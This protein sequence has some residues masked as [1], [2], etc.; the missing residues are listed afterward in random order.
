[1]SRTHRERSEIWLFETITLRHVAWV[2]W[3][4]SYGHC[5]RYLSMHRSMA[6]FWK[7]AISA[8]RL[9]LLVTPAMWSPDTHA[10]LPGLIEDHAARLEPTGCYQ[11][12]KRFFPGPGLRVF[13]R[14]SLSSRAFNVL[15]L[16]VEAERLRRL[17]EVV[18]VFP[19]RDV[20]AVVQHVP[21]GAWSVPRT[22]RLLLTLQARCSPWMSVLRLLGVWIVRLIRSGCCWRKPQPQPWGISQKTDS[23]PTLTRTVDHALLYAQGPFAPQEIL[24]I[25]DDTAL[26]PGWP[27]H[28]GEARIPYVVSE[29]IPMPISYAISRLLGV[30]MMQFLIP[31]AWRA[32][33]YREA[34]DL[35]DL[36]FWLG[37]Y[38]VV[39]EVLLLH[40]RPR[41]YVTWD[42]Y[43]IA[44]NVRTMVFERHGIR[45]AGYLH[46]DLFYPHYRFQHPYVHLLFSPGPRYRTMFASTWEGVGRT[47]VTGHLRIQKVLE[48]LERPPDQQAHPIQKPRGHLVVAYDTSYAPEVGY[49]DDVFDAFLR[50]LLMLVDAYPSVTVFL[51]RKYRQTI[52]SFERLKTRLLTHPRVHVLYE[53]DSYYLLSLADS[54]VVLGSSTIGIEALSC[55]KPVLYFDPR[56]NGEGI[57][58]RTHDPS[59]VCDSAEALR[60]RYAGMLA[61]DYISEAT[62]DR[63]VAENGRYMEARPLSIIREE[64]ARELSGDGRS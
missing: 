17:G 4:L 39:N 6:A 50:S 33:A 42:I 61:G 54:V 60:D 49:A 7:R 26:W 58:Y 20:P 41:V 10:R 14:K 22:Y 51:K 53:V 45:C 5:L 11:W 47:V 34:K 19:A 63:I 38:G 43:S 2:W 8:G 28:A 24:H 23:A 44:N 36:V 21:R 3:G 46:G 16:C 12:L 13:L 56:S 55:H 35:S 29:R 15:V 40:H 32:I 52:P 62:W 18:R 25:I 31:F 48:H 1:M 9:Q 57:L 37:R 59:L 27:Q 64:L 30:W